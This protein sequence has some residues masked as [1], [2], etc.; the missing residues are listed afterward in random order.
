MHLV[1]LTTVWPENW[2]RIYFGRVERAKETLYPESLVQDHTEFLR[3]NI[4]G[5]THSLTNTQVV[6]IS[7]Y[8]EGLCWF[9]PLDLNHRVYGSIY[10]QRERRLEASNRRS[11]HAWQMPRYRFV[12]SICV[13]LCP[14]KIDTK[15]SMEFVPSPQ[16]KELKLSIFLRCSREV[17]SIS[18]RSMYFDLSVMTPP[19]MTH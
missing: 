19:L 12:L 10:A 3:Q 16:G 2:T 6:H 17:S 9:H 11:V 13:Q 5:N 15:G 14:K 8:P 4:L 1:S 7:S 18:C